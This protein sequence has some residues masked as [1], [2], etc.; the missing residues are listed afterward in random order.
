MYTPQAF[1]DSCNQNHSS[2]NVVVAESVVTVNDGNVS[3]HLQC[4]THLDAW[5]RP[6]NSLCRCCNDTGYGVTRCAGTLYPRTAVLPS[7]GTMLE[8]KGV[9]MLR[10]MI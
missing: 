8:L 2:D 3:R 9:Q 4:A 6:E 7:S 5:S 10:T 1:I